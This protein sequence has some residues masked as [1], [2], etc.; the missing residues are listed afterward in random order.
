VIRYA[1]LWRD[2][3]QRGRQEGR[4]ARPCAVVLVTADDS[5]ERI[6]TVLPVTH[7]PPED[8]NLAVEIPHATKQRLGL[9]DE[10]SWILL[11]EA[12]RFAWPGP[13]LRPVQPGDPAGV[14]Y[15]LLPRALFKQV[16]AKLAAAITAQ[17]V[18]VVPR[19]G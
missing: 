19:T 9:D 13:D 2:E 3:H 8:Q 10:R 4:K 17:T 6:V 5:G 12:N 18:Q 14:A 15:G 11:T 1:Y 16:T 7:T